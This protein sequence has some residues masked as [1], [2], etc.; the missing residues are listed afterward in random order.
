MERNDAWLKESAVADADLGW[1]RHGRCLGEKLRN[2]L[3]DA[4]GEVIKAAQCS[5][6]R[7]VMSGRKCG[8]QSRELR[9]AS[10]ACMLEMAAEEKA[11][12][13]GSRVHG[14]ENH[15]SDVQG[16]IKAAARAKDRERQRQRRAPGS[17]ACCAAHR[18]GGLD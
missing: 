6:G 11:R 7:E 12:G 15:L 13:E 4:E 8:R 1:E 16:E 17:G 3:R 18:S 10:S 14:Y 5:S 9:M 2:V